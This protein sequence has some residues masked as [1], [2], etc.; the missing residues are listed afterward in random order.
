M[1]KLLDKMLYHG[2]TPKQTKDNGELQQIHS[3]DHLDRDNGDVQHNHNGDKDEPNGALQ[4]KGNGEFLE[5]FRE[6][7]VSTMDVSNKAEVRPGEEYQVEEDP[8]D[9]IQDSKEEYTPNDLKFHKCHKD[10]KFHKDHKYPK[11]R[12]NQRLRY[13]KFLESNSHN[14]C[15]RSHSH[16]LSHNLN[17]NL[18]LSLNL[19]P[20]ILADQVNQLDLN[21][22]LEG[23]Q[24]YTMK[25]EKTKKQYAEVTPNLES[26]GDG[27]LKCTNG[28]GLHPSGIMVANFVAAR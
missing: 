14:L 13:P 1:H 15:Q 5:D 2:D 8:A 19:N 9:Y 27:Q 10:H 20:L 28:H 18:S 23:R 16:N 7:D 26:R 12:N 3:G 4:F 6:Q 17:H 22:E 25:M 24:S 11:Y 21:V